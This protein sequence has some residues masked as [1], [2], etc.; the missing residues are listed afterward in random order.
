M[1]RLSF[2]RPL[3]RA[4][5]C[6][7]LLALPLAS[8][9]NLAVAPNYPKLAIRIGPKLGGVTRDAQVDLS[10]SSLRDGRFQKA[11]ASRVTEAMAVRPLLIRI[12]N[13][14]RFELFGELTA[15][16][17]VRGAKGQLIERSYLEEYCAR[18]EGQAAALAADIIPKLKDVQDYYRARGAIFLY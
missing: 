12:N 4:G 18:T 10:W 15:P 1:A 2:S 13:E 6:L 11:V 8:A 14:I 3:V 7:V 9:W 16:Q 5:F 17:V